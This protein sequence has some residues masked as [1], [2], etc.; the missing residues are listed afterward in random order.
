MKNKVIVGLVA[1]SFLMMAGCNDI[2]GLLN[3]TKA[4]TVSVKGKSKIV[5]M[6]AHDTSLDFRKDKV[7]AK[8]K[9]SGDTFKVEMNF[10]EGTQIPSNGNFELKE[11]QSGQPFDVL[12]LVATQVTD[13]DLQRERERCQYQGYGQICDPRG[14]HTVPV[15]REGLRDITFYDRLTDQQV[16]L[17]LTAP[18]DSKT[19]FASFDGRIRSTERI[20]TREGMCF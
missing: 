16:H 11:A 4:F 12:G 3:V 17:D 15:T 2:S 1:V 19:K 13:S 6:G 5:E 7:I 14:C 20:V 10:A 8:I 9:T 18:S